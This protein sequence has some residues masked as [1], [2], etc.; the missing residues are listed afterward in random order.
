MEINEDNYP[1]FYKFV[2]EITHI[3]TLAAIDARDENVKLGLPNVIGK[4]G[5]V[6]HQLPI[7]KIRQIYPKI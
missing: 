5:R 3:A 2:A 4:N 7:G 6:Y 1:E